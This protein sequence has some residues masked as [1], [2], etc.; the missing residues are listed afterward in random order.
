MDPGQRPF[1]QASNAHRNLFSTRGDSNCAITSKRVQPKSMQ[2]IRMTLNKDTTRQFLRYISW[3]LL[4][5]S[6]LVSFVESLKSE[7]PLSH[8]LCLMPASGIPKHI[9]KAEDL[10]DIAKWPANDELNNKFLHELIEYKTDGIQTMI[11]DKRE[12]LLYLPEHCTECMLHPFFEFDAKGNKVMEAHSCCNLEYQT[13]FTGNSE[14]CQHD[15]I[16]NYQR[17]NNNTLR[18]ALEAEIIAHIEDKWLEIKQTHCTGIP[19]LRGTYSKQWYDFLH[20]PAWTKDNELGE[21]LRTE[22]KKVMRDHNLIYNTATGK[23]VVLFI[24]YSE[25]YDAM[26]EHAKHPKSITLGQLLEHSMKSKRSLNYTKLSI[27]DRFGQILD[28][29]GI[30]LTNMACCYQNTCTKYFRH[31]ILCILQKLKRDDLVTVFREMSLS[32]TVQLETALSSY[33][34]E[35]HDLMCESI[36]LAVDKT[37]TFHLLID[38]HTPEDQEICNGVQQ[39]AHAWFVVYKEQWVK[40][41]LKYFDAFETEFFST[42]S[43]WNKTVPAENAN[44]EKWKQR[45]VN[46]F[47]DYIF[48][49]FEPDEADS[50]YWQQDTTQARVRAFKNLFKMKPKPEV[51]NIVSALISSAQDKQLDL[52]EGHKYR[53]YFPYENILHWI[54]L[55]L[56]DDTNGI[57]NKSCSRFWKKEPDNVFHLL[58]SLLA[59]KRQVN[60]DP[61]ADKQNKWVFDECCPLYQY[62]QDNSV[63]TILPHPSATTEKDS[64]NSEGNSNGSG[65]SEGNGDENTGNSNG[66]GGSEG[67]GDDN[68]GNSNGSEGSQ[69]NGDGDDDGGNSAE[70]MDLDSNEHV[71]TGSADVASLLNSSPDANANVQQ[72]SI[73]QQ[74]GEMTKNLSEGIFFSFQKFD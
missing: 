59:M 10:D 24:S 13:R 21:H 66:S 58:N 18:S 4:E 48:T 11:H 6:D 65:G 67:N 70:D 27:F 20:N 34:F 60:D 39:L 33:D 52:H 1:P 73:V 8:L 23:N 12:L 28:T 25:F 74:L 37:Q 54:T 72:G 71:Q 51:G 64:D 47:C 69:G 29:R 43:C 63:E 15:I 35:I 45:F 9:T 68:T 50:E 32:N 62:V 26:Q 53:F 19:N 14:V 61:D 56:L 42:I 22:W 31:T 41:A 44:F 5:K 38:E 7:P 3:H 2:M 30:V 16:E 46:A 40:K 55:A 57:L 36:Q 49:F 17:Q